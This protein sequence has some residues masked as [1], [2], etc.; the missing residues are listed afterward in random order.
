M[1]MHANAHITEIDAG[2]LSMIALP[3][4]VTAVIVKAAQ[5]AQ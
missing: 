2:H 4:A 5:A 1:S 3:S